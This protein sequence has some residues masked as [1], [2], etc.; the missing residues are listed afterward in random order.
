MILSF[1]KQFH[2]KI[3]DGEKIHTIRE[4]PTNRW[5]AGM[6]IHF[7]T[8][9]R[10]KKYKQFSK[11]ECSGTERIQ[12][13][14][15]SDGPVVF[16]G[17]GDLSFYQKGFNDRGMLELVKNDG[18]KSIDDFFEWFDKDFEGKIIHWTGLLYD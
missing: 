1:K 16:I 6:K 13:V 14:W 5:K 11:G 2:K 10:T 15:N 12:I 9:V 17:E 7:A 8:G 4:D 18:F 3:I